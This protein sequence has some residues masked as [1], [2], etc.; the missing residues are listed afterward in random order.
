MSTVISESPVLPDD[1]PLD[2]VSLGL[3][4]QM[5]ESRLLTS[6]DRGVLLDGLLVERMPKGTRHSTASRKGLRALKAKIRLDLH[7]RPEQPVSLRSGPE[8]ADNEPEPDL[9]VVPGADDAYLN[10]HPAPAD[11]ALL[12]EIADTSLAHDRASL[13]L[14]ARAGI[15][16]VWI[17][18]LI[19]MKIEVYSDPWGP[20]TTPGYN[21]RPD[22]GP[23][24][25]LTI[26]IDGT[27]AARWPPAIC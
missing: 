14:Y 2:R 3:Y 10:R 13:R 19:D 27:R 24:G 23:E 18:N 6:K 15:S 16:C 11:V 8:G 9:A 25:S 7:V 5:A 26:S 12:V 22:F 4:H 1:S 20:S 17:V 21:S